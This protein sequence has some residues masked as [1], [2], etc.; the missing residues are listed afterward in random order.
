MYAI[1][2]RY[3]VPSER[4]DE[5]EKHYGSDGTWARLFRQAPGFVRTELFAEP[6]KPGA[7]LTVDWWEGEQEFRA[8][9]EAEGS[10]Y[11]ALDRELA[12]LSSDQ[13]CIGRYVLPAGVTE[14][15]DLMEQLR[16][17]GVFS[18]TDATFS[19]D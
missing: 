15:T 1:L 13:Q 16:Q 9:M 4:A 17:W 11:D 8:F 7:Y 10:T 6:T 2:F 19:P 14:L 3:A 5:F 12:P 18:V